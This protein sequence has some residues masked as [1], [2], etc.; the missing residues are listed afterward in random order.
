MVLSPSCN[1]LIQTNGYIVARILNPPPLKVI[2][3]IRHQKQPQNTKAC[4]SYFHGVLPQHHLYQAAFLDS[5][6]STMSD[7]PGRTPGVIFYYFFT[8]KQDVISGAMAPSH[9][10]SFLSLVTTLRS[11]TRL[12]SMQWG[13][14]RSTATRNPERVGSYD[15]DQSIGLQDF[16]LEPFENTAYC[17]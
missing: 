3:Y 8:R 4:L 2:A 6:V 16:H 12:V 9:P 14:G 11:C 15:R 17:G 13:S 1:L 7:G 5:S 10:I